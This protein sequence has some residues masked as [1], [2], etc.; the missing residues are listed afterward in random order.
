MHPG[1]REI[2][3]SAH[4]VGVTVGDDG[5]GHVPG[6]ES[7]PLDLPDG[8]V[9]LVEEEPD[10]V[11]ELLTQ[12]LDGPLHVEQSDAGVHEGEAVLVF[13]EEAVTDRLRVRGWPQK[14]AVDVVNGR[15][16]VAI[17]FRVAG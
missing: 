11:D 4:M 8:G 3:E 6:A 14:S 12:P 16:R 7:Q 9:G 15:H 17:A 2:G 10:H 13:Q 5:V 1:L